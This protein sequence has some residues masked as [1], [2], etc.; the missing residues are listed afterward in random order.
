M[1]WRFQYRN[2]VFISWFF[3]RWEN[4]LGRYAPLL[5]TVHLWVPLMQTPCPFLSCICW[6]RSKLE[7]AGML[8]KVSQIRSSSFLI[9]GSFVYLVLHITWSL[10]CFEVYFQK[11]QLDHQEVS[12]GDPDKN[13]DQDLRSSWSWKNVEIIPYRQFFNWSQ[14]ES[15]TLLMFPNF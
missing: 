7:W 2:V 5:G 6:V 3:W 8:K 9:S 10:V 1:N 12:T 4:V 15:R 14:G 13:R 11:A